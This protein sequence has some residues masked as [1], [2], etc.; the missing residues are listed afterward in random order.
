MTELYIEGVAVVLPEDMNLSVKRENPFFTKNGE[1]TYELTLPL[2]NTINATLYKHLNRLNSTAEITTK[3][4]AVLIADNRVYC[5][6]TEIITGWTEKTVSIQIASG[7]S[8]LNYF[9]G[10][11]R[12][13]SSLELGSA[14]VP[15][16]TTGRLNYIEKTYPDIDF[17]LPPVMNEGSGEIINKWDVERYKEGGTV[18]GRLI[19]NGTDRK[20]VV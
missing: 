18:K 20:S 19:D 15:G 12:L 5:N 6:G 17:C 14:V 10:S 11:D 4:R 3:R 2:G 13:I 1:Y 7:N 9:I 8:E 16:A